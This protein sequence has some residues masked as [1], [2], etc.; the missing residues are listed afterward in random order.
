MSTGSCDMLVTDGQMDRQT[1]GQTDKQT[2]RQTD[3]GEEY[4]PP[5]ERQV[6]NIIRTIQVGYPAS[7]IS[8]VEYENNDTIC[9]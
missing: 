4:N 2:D 5:P 8:F 9:I 1:N 3:A 6:I 7:S